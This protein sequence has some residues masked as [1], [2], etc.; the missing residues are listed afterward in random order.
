MRRRPAREISD[1]VALATAPT[2]LAHGKAQARPTQEEDMNIPPE[3]VAAKLALEDPL[4]QIPGVLGID[5]GLR[6]PELEESDL[7]IRIFVTDAAAPPPLLAGVLATVSFPVVIEQRTFDLLADRDRY[8]PVVGGIEIGAFHQSVQT[9]YGTLGGLA[10]DTLFPGGRDVGVS[11]AHVIASSGLNVTIVQGDPIVQ[12]AAAAVGSR[13]IGRL[14][15]WDE[16]NDIAVFALDD[17]ISAT[18]RIEQ[19]GPY[20]GMAEAKIN[21]LVFKRGRTTGLTWGKVVSNHLRLF[22]RADPGTGFEVWRL[23]TNNPAI[24]CEHGDSGS[25]IVSQQYQ[26]VGIL[27]IGGIQP[28]WGVGVP[29]YASG[30]ANQI[31]P[32]AASVGVTF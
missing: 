2:T 27:A 13:Q 12:P 21:D 29:G 22:G 31:I 19:V 1:I 8:D 18:R 26:V 7:V 25:L 16:N 9:G 14:H 6:E 15:R 24:F 30:I 11:C 20:S 32:A 3:M 4:G 5:I 23:G 10:T 17:G 28:T